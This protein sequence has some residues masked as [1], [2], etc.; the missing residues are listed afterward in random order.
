MEDH[1]VAD[2][3]RR[4]NSAVF[5]DI[6]I[7]GAPAGRIRL[8]LFK[9]QVPRAA[10]NYRALCT[11]ETKRGGAPWGFKGAR[12]HRVIAGFMAQGGDVLRG[13]GTGRAS[14]YGDK[15]DDEPAGLKL[16]H[17]TPGLLSSANSGPHTNGCQFFLTLA[18]APHLDGKHVVFGRVMDRESLLT[19]RKIEH[20][21]VLPGGQHKP[22]L[23]VTIAECGEL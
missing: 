3:L 4:G 6:A 14:I 16:R 8:E 23:D 21:P 22:R 1:S 19:L 11:G 13:D 18:P 15:F 17:S 5:L 12:F 10:E 7:G 20:V 9:A 2:V